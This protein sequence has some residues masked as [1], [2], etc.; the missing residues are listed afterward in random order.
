MI[1]VIAIIAL[2]SLPF[3]SFSQKNSVAELQKKYKNG[4]TFTLNF[5]N[6]L[7]ILAVSSS[8][9]EYSADDIKKLKKSI[10]RQDFEELMSIKNGKGQLQ[11]HLMDRKGKP[12]QLIMIADN[13]SE[14]FIALDF[15]EPESD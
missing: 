14:G 8:S 3:V 7:Q 5:D 11:V 15:T 10:R 4:N 12:A 13:E 1:K 9:K 6:S 2:L